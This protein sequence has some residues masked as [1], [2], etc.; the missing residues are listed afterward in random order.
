[1]EAIPTM[2][3]TTVDIMAMDMVVT[4]VERR[5]KPRPHLLLRL[6]L[7]LMLKLIP[8]V[9]IME[10]IPTMVDTTVDIMAMDMVVTGVERRGK[11]RPHLL[12]RLMLLLRR[13]LIPGVTIM[14]A[15]PTM[16]DT[17]VDI[18]GT[19]MLVTI[20]VESKVRRSQDCNNCTNLNTHIIVKLGSRNLPYLLVI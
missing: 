16:V 11:P 9:T 13:K 6:M 3:D 12:L 4:G 20:G 17:M 8:G 5:G 15:I 7:L 14:E 1:M 10:A 19:A 2:V 18:T